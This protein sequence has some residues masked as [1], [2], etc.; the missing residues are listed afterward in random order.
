[1]LFVEYLFRAQFIF[2][3]NGTNMPAWCI[4]MGYFVPGSMFNYEIEL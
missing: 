2:A 3:R 1:M 4:D